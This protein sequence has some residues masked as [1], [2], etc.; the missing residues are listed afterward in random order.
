MR[1]ENQKLHLRIKEAND[2]VLQMDQQVAEASLEQR[3]VQQTIDDL[4]RK[5]AD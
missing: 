1:E 4:K 5:V 3:Q 2:N